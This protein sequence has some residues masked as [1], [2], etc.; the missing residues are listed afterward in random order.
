[1]HLAVLWWDLPHL[2][3]F[4]AQRQVQPFF[5][6]LLMPLENR[7]SGLHFCSGRLSVACD[8]SRR[9]GLSPGKGLLPPPCLSA[10]KNPILSLG[11]LPRC[12]KSSATS[13]QPVWQSVP[14]PAVESTGNGRAE[15]SQLLAAA[16]SGVLAGYASPD[17][18]G[19]TQRLCFASPV[20]V[21]HQGKPRA[22]GKAF[23]TSAVLLVLEGKW[24]VWKSAALLCRDFEP[25]L[26][27]GQG[28]QRKPHKEHRAERRAQGS[29]GVWERHTARPANAE[30][31]LRG[32]STRQAEEKSPPLSCHGGEQPTEPDWEQ[33]DGG[34]GWAVEK[35]I[36]WIDL[37]SSPQ[38]PHRALFS[39]NLRYDDC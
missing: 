13:S 27:K 33:W 10:V 37:T 16:A 31:R 39:Y 5:P 2:F 3:V 8:S 4:A 18:P 29:T 1:M 12:G 35:N 9:E 36:L 15:R 17:E 19:P 23:P 14:R 21:C 28:E 34:S 26:L 30:S 25:P 7:S 22:L 6:R 11:I 20:P 38:I 32:V 24:L